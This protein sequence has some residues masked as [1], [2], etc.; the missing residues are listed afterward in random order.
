LKDNFFI[1]DTEDFL[2]DEIIKDLL[3]MSEAVNYQRWILNQFRDFPSKR[4][5]ELGAGIGT[6]TKYLLE[7]EIVIP[8]DLHEGCVKILKERF[9]E[10]DNVLPRQLDISDPQLI[11]LASYKPDAVITINVLEH[12]ADDMA[13]I[14]NVFKIL[15]PQG[16]FLIFVPAFNFLFGKTDM[17]VGHMRRYSKEELKKKL[18]EA[19]FTIKKM[20]YLN[21]IGFF[22]WLIN[23]ILKREEESIR[24][25]K[26]FDN[27]IVPWLSKVEKVFKP[28]F[29]LSLVAIAQ[30]E[31]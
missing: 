18:M 9:K 3:V 21:T 25:V 30:K 22:G 10:Y 31:K 12:I 2:K 7:K 20:H 16:G 4:I 8:I 24:Q 5:V 13:V 28:P 19:G 17:T 29:G 23:K 26:F 14:E 11:E 1:G 27:I 6:F 15:S